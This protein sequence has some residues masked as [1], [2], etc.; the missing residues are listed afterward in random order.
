MFLMMGN[1]SQGDLG[2]WDP[3]ILAGPSR[4]KKV[5]KAHLFPKYF[6]QEGTPVPT[7]VP[8]AR[9]VLGLPVDAG[10]GGAATLAGSL[11]QGRGAWDT[12]S[13]PPHAPVD[14]VSGKTPLESKTGL[15]V[16]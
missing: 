4:E 10:D 8:S 1:S 5:D 6:C 15:C 16:L 13:S 14:S 12:W 7:S 2:T 11:H 9:T 3:R